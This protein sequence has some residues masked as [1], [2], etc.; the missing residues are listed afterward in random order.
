MKKIVN[1]F[2]V[3]IK[4][5]DGG[6]YGVV[7]HT[8]SDGHYLCLNGVTESISIETLNELING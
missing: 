1:S 6:K 2:I 8:E 5:D 7:Y 3:F 4:C